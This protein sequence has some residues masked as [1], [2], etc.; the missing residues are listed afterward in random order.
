M[1]Y[2]FYHQIKGGKSP[3]TAPTYV[4]PE[5]AGPE[6]AAGEGPALSP[7]RCTIC[8]YVYDPKAGDPA[9]GVAPGTAW[10]DVPDTWVCPVCGAPKS[11]FEKTN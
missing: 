9:N 7:Y 6:E 3:K 2:A 11:E 5:K 8:G 4:A 1:T 10:E